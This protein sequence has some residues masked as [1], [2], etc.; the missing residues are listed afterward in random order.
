VATLRTAIRGLREQGLLRT[1]HRPGER[2]E[3]HRHE[4]PGAL[5]LSAEQVAVLAVLLLRGPQTAAELRARSDRMHVF[6][7]V[8]QVEQVL[9]G[10]AARDEPLARRLERQPGRKE[11]RWVQVLAAGGPVPVVAPET[12]V[13]AVQVAQEVVRSLN[14][15][16]G[17]RDVEAALAVFTGD[18]VPGGVRRP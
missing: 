1:V 12:G 11:P 13:S 18:A 8:E 14:A 7:S 9:A 2:S 4:L 3:K 15:A 10:L 16:T 6:G 17:A 5:D